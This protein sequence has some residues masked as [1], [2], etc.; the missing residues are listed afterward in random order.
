MKK[1]D[2]MR[3]DTIEE[4]H[5]RKMIRN[6]YIDQTQGDLLL[7]QFKAMRELG[8]IPVSEDSLIPK[9]LDD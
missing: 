4:R 2:T 9:E 3:F 1:D 7:A 5:I 8:R 6:G